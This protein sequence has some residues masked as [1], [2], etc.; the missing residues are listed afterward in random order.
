MKM[1]QIMLDH[2]DKTYAGAV[3]AV[4]D[5]RLAIGDKRAAKPRR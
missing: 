3:K 5:S 4:S 2:V 1:A